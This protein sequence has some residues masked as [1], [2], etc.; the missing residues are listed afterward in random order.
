MNE[1]KRLEEV[2]NRYSN[3]KR[4]AP[5]VIN[6]CE[7]FSQKLGSPPGN[8]GMDPRLPDQD[9]ERDDNV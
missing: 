8:V 9:V 7:G 6:E 4:N 1:R 5:D 3:L 2:Q